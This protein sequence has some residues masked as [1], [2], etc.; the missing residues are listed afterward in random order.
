MTLKNVYLI[1]NYNLKEMPRIKE[2]KETAPSWT[3]FNFLDVITKLDKSKTNKYT[4]MLIRVLTDKINKTYQNQEDLKYIAEELGNIFGLELHNFDVAEQVIFYRL[5]ESILNN[6]DY[7]LI[8]NFI[9]L[10]ER[11]IENGV[12]VQK[13]ETLEDMNRY[14][15]IASLK[16]V[17]KELRNQVVVDYDSDEWLIIRPITFEASIKYGAGTKWCTTSE[18]NPDHFFRYSKRGCLIYIINKLN[19]YKVACYKNFEEKQ[20]EFYNQEDIRVDSM[21]VDLPIE[22]LGRIKDIIMSTIISNKELDVEK[23][24][25]SE[26]LIEKN[27]LKIRLLEPTEPGHWVGEEEIQ[28]ATI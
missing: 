13:I 9:E 18:S 25:M 16:M 3:K 10:N 20:I 11:K 4:P 19:G 7:Q 5:Y 12:D 14:L 28:S 27:Q 2:I 21:M 15:C 1:F 22:I 17:N 8:N 26:K 6:S 23:W 24:T